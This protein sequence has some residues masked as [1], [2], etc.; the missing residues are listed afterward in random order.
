MIKK[1]FLDLN[2]KI[3]YL[4]ISY[5]TVGGFFNVLFKCSLKNKENKVYKIFI[6]SS[7]LL[8]RNLKKKIYISHTI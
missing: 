8:K 7:N 4:E 6:N 1:I 5:D 3:I 2:A